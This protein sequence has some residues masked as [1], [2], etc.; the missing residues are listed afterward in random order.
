MLWLCFV[1]FIDQWHIEAKRQELQIYPL[2]DLAL[3]RKNK[4]AIS[5]IHNLRQRKRNLYASK[6]RDGFDNILL[7]D[8]VEDLAEQSD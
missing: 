6:S 2:Q 4:M 1:C 7:Y 8:P 5:K 3:E